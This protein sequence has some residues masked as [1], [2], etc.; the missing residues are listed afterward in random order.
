MTH[1]RAARLRYSL[2]RTS[3]PLAARLEQVAWVVGAAVVTAASAQIS[4]TLPGSPVPFTLQPVAVMMAGVVLGARLG[5]ASQVTYLALGLAGASAFAWSP[6]LLP[7]LGRLLGPTG[8][9]LL[10]FPLAAFVAGAVADR[11]VRR[12]PLTAAA[13]MLSGTAVLHV[14]GW[15]WALA[16]LPGAPVAAIVGGSLV[17]DVVKV[18]LAAPIAARLAGAFRR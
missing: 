15:P 12:R 18:L 11:T 16:L 5:A 2:L 1:Y 10:A 6:V 13:A 7:G 9:F 8:G 4:V 14:I 17:A 3:S